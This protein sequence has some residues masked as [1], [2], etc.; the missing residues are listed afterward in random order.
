MFW[1]FGHVISYLP[2]QDRTQASSTGRPNLNYWITRE[3]PYDN[4]LVSLT[5]L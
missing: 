2:D 1:S 5:H 4:I 3:V